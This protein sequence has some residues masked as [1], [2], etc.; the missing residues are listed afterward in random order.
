MRFNSTITI[1]SAVAIVAVAIGISVTA[2]EKDE[3]KSMPLMSVS[4]NDSHVRKPVFKRI[5]TQVEWSQIWASHLGTTV[6]DAYRSISEVDFQRC[7]LI[8][9]FLGDSINVRGVEIHP[10]RET[11]DTIFVRF[12]GTCYQTERKGEHHWPYAFILI[13]ATSKRIVLEEGM[14]R[15]TNEPL[16]FSV[17]SV[18]DG[19]KSAA[20]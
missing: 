8:A 4:G 20:K 9:I 18:L 3:K 16:I 11:G 17:H 2:A 7:A 12:S 10:L 19:A 5:T 15:Q 14:R 13:P 1:L 6:D